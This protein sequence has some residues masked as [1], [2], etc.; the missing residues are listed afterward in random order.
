M[1]VSKSLKQYPKFQIVNN[2]HLNC[3]N[4]QLEWRYKYRQ[5]VYIV[6]YMSCEI[7]N[8]CYAVP[9]DIPNAPLKKKSMSKIPNIK[10]KTSNKLILK[11]YN[12]TL[13]FIM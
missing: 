4:L 2:S 6:S 12:R 8:G 7:E 13:V 5:G 11:K 3:A 1:L 9:G 10:L